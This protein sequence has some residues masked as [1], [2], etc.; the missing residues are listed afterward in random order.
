MCQEIRRFIMKASKAVMESIAVAALTMALSIT[1]VSANGVSNV[2]NVTIAETQE[3]GT[4]TDRGEELSEEE[5]KWQNKLMAKV[6][7]FLYVRAEADG[8]SEIVGKMYK[9]DRAVI[10]EVGETWTKIKS[11]NVT[12]YVRNDYCVTGSEALAYAKE[13]CDTVAKITA[14]ALRV[15]KEAS[16]DSAI[17]T[18]VAE[19][20]KLV[21]DTEA[22]TAE[23]WVAVKLNSDTYY[24]S[25]DYVT[26]SLKTGKAVTLEE[27]AAAQ[28]A[29]AT[30]T[31]G[32]STVATS[33]EE[34]LLAAIIECEAGSQNLQCMTAVGAVVLNRVRSSSFE[35]TIRGVIYQ[36]GQFGPASS[37]R[38]ATRLAN[39]VSENARKAARAALN[40]SDPTGGKLFFIETSTGHSGVVIGPLVFY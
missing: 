22:E 34:T 20:Q 8:E 21:V 9:G 19:G 37:G 4:V 15:R 33:D 13:N 6:D 24:V 17:I 36:R 7:N 26:V 1:T 16:I 18:L 23:G 38:L 2:T 28:K 12:G 40:G 11:G 39:G 14:D 27:E 29:A 32:S 35:N 5:L 10:K 25:G 30:Q 31:Q 3:N